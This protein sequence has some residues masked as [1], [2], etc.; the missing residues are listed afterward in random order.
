MRHDP[1]LAQRRSSKRHFLKRLS[2]VSA[3]PALATLA[4]TPACAEGT[5]PDRPL[6]IVV[7]FSAGGPLDIL[8]RVMAEKMQQT[9]KQTV[10]VENQTGAAGNIGARSV[11]NAAPDG[12]TLLF[13]IDTPFTLSPSV[14]KQMPFSA[15]ALEPVALLGSSTLT[16]AVNPAT[17][18]D[19]LQALI[20]KSK[21]RAVSFS[22]AGQ[23]SPGHIAALML[24]EATGMRINHI[25]YRGNAPAVVAL[26]SGEVEA[27]ILSTSGLIPQIQ[28]HS[29]LP[30]AVAGS[31]RSALLPALPTVTELGYPGLELEFL[32]L[33]MLPRDTPD[34]IRQTLRKAMMDALSQPAIRTRLEQLDILASDLSAAELDKKL[35]AM[36]ANYSR[37]IKAHRLQMD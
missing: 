1:T 14:Y 32:F 8:A 35:E 29:L 20:R 9:L 33:A 11:A 27:G 21:N 7:N 34:A 19:S 2:A 37:I 31:T 15:T 26:L 16:V 28:A 4:A 25:P 13:S 18:I 17:G 12:Y 5:F 3:L 24:A 22:S 10:I 30:L 6:K 23:G 36:R